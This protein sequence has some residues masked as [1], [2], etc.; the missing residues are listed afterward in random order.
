MN[1]SLSYENSIAA[2]VCASHPHPPVQERYAYGYGGRIILLLILLTM[3]AAPAQGSTLEALW[4][5][6]QSRDYRAPASNELEQ[7]EQLFRR[8][9]AGETGE[10]LAADWAALG[11]QLEQV[12]EQGHVFT[13]VRERPDQRWGRGFYTFAARSASRPVLQAPHAL[14]DKFTGLIALRLFAQGQFAA[15]AWSTAP[16]RY[17]N[18]DDETV[19]ADLAHLPESHLL[20]FSKA[21]AFSQPASAILQLHG[22]AAEKRKTEAG[23]TA[24]A[25]ISAGQSQPTRAAEQT[26]HC[27]GGVITEPVLLYPIQIGELGG[28][29]NQ[30]GQTLRALGSSAFV[31]IELVRSVREQLRVNAALRDQF[32]GCLAGVRL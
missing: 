20:A 2:T 30:I 15:G 25:I 10:A 31:H 21:A 17:Q 28:T 1:L 18:E 9:F 12:T 5:D 4:N 8:T 32:G 14:S 13:V 16:R 19:D 3:I 11:F 24:G 7:A 26:A 22:F 6:S 27:L 23:R 29:A